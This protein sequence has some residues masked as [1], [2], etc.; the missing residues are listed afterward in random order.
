MLADIAWQGGTRDAMLQELEVARRLV[1]GVS[2]SRI[3]V[4]VLAEVARYEMLAD[5]HLDEAIEF[6][7]EALVLAEELGLEDLRAAR[8]EHHRCFASGH[9]R[10]WWARQPR[11]GK[12]SRSTSRG[13][14]SRWDL[15]DAAT[16][17][18]RRSTSSTARSRGPGRPRRSRSSWPATIGQQ[19]F[20]RFVE[21]G[22]AVGNRYSDGSVGRVPVARVEAIL[23]E[24]KAGTR[25][26]QTGAIVLLPGID[27]AR[28]RRRG[29]CGD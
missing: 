5:W 25:F 9:G 16:T 6:G 29:R 21:A 19:A 2:R 23:A 8:A 10:S 3:Q 18:G 17:T 28:S 24:A 1:D 12:Q 26:Y 7:R 15:V 14:S 20:V 27:Q 22:P 13:T 4:A 11:R